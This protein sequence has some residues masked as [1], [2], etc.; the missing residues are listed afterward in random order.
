MQKSR[1]GP[2]A[3]EVGRI[4]RVMRFGMSREWRL[5]QVVWVWEVRVRWV[6]LVKTLKRRSRGRALGSS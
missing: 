2:V 4:W 5:A 1:K 6:V 3:P